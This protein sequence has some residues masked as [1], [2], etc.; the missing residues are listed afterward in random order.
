MNVA[1]TLS[2]ARTTFENI[3][4]MFTNVVAVA[5]VADIADDV[6]NDG[7][8]VDVYDGGDDVDCGDAIYVVFDGF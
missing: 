7:D 3:S 1:R 4:C 5:D 8:D 2:N 6:D